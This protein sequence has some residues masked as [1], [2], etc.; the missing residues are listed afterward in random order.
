MNTHTVLAATP[1]TA[2]R[3][4]IVRR[5]K[6]AGSRM[7][8]LIAAEARASAM[9]PERAEKVRALLREQIAEERTRATALLEDEIRASGIVLN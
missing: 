3:A 7:A 2:V 5:Q 8:L 4:D 9:G 6:A 1:T